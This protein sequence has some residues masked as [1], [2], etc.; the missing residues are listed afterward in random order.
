MY[1]VSLHGHGTSAWPGFSGAPIECR[2]GTKSAS[3]PIRSSTSVPIRAMMRIEHT[4]YAE[5]VISTPNIGASASSGPMQNG[6]T[7]IVRPCMLPRYRSVITDFI[8]SGAIQLLVVPASDSSAE[9]M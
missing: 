8:S 6:I 1:F 9:Q 5:S 7:Y 3:S 2:Q 4:T